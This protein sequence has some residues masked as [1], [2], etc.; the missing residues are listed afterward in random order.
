M[1]YFNNVFISFLDFK[2]VSSVAVY[3]EPVPGHM[4]WG[5]FIPQVECWGCGWLQVNA[6]NYLGNALQ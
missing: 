1:D 5:A 2:Y 6:K 3:A 4:T